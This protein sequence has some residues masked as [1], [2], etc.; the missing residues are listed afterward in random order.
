LVRL[1]A[2]ALRRDELAPRTKEPIR[3]DRAL[4][5]AIDHRRERSLGSALRRLD[6][7]DLHARLDRALR[8]LRSLEHLQAIAERLEPSRRADRKVRRHVDRITG[9]LAAL[10][11][12]FEE[13]VDHVRKRH[14]PFELAAT[15]LEWSER[16]DVID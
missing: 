9:R 10:A 1:G 7:R 6:R 3:I 11:P 8:E 4:P 2:E 13:E 5:Q 14:R 15:L 12:L 16:H